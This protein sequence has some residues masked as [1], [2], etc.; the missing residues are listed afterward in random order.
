MP[1]QRPAVP[2]VR[3]GHRPG[4]GAQSRRQRGPEDQRVEVAGVVGEVDA[5]GRRRLRPEPAGAAADQEAHRADQRRARGSRAKPGARCAR[6]RRAMVRRLPRRT[7]QRTMPGSAEA[8]AGD[9]LA[10]PEQ[11][12]RPSRRPSGAA[13]PSARGS[14]AAGRARRRPGGRRRRRWRRARSR[15]RGSASRRRRRSRRGSRCPRPGPAPRCRARPVGEPSPPSTA[16]RPSSRFARSRS[17]TRA[18]AT[19]QPAGQGAA[20]EP[21]RSRRARLQQR[22]PGEEREADPGE[23][24]GVRGHAGA[25]QRLGEASHGTEPAR[26]ERSAV[27]NGIVGG[28]LCAHG[29]E[30]SQPATRP[31]SAISWYR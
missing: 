1:P 30:T 31:A 12:A 6:S 13:W 4:G 10:E 29:R 3:R 15:G 27:G 21:Q 22:E 18:A 7:T 28:G 8:A 24:D 14:S 16:T 26:G 25:G 2:I 23:R 9:R 17:W 5:L 19:S 11:A 20:A